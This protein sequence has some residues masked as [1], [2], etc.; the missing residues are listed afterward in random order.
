MCLQAHLQAP[1]DAQRLLLPVSH[2]TWL[3]CPIVC[4]PNSDLPCR[5][6]TFICGAPFPAT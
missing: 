3:L 1:G 5:R 6:A 4:I 2:I